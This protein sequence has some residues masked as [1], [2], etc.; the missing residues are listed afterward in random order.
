[1]NYQLIVKYNA[2]EDL[3][4][5]PSPTVARVDGGVCVSFP[6]LC[7]NGEARIY[8]DSEAATMLR[9]K[10]T[11]ALHSTTTSTTIDK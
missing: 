2:H 6:V 4:R 7:Q 10:L 5:A 9:D 8:F 3:D 1:M 11:E